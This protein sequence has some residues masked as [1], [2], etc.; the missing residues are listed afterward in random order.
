M[1]EHGEVFFAGDVPQSAGEPALT[2]A[3]QAH[4]ILPRNIR[5]KLLSAIHITLAQENASS[6]S[7]DSSTEVGST[8]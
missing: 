2:D 5:L 3:A 8:L 4:A 6:R 1:V 7:G